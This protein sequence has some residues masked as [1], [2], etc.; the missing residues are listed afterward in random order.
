MTKLRQLAR[1][2]LGEYAKQL[3]GSLVVGE[4]NANPLWKT[5]R[6]SATKQNV[7]LPYDPAIAPLAIDPR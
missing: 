2:S 4:E 5:I 6:Q 7:H 1:L 3:Q